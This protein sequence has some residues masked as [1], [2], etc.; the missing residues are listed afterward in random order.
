MVLIYEGILAVSSIGSLNHRS[1]E[2]LEQNTTRMTGKFL[3]QI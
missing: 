2:T 1:N 3:R